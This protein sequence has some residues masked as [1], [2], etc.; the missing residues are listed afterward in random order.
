MGV[1]ALSFSAIFVREAATDATTITFFRALYAL[2][3][4]VLAW[5]SIRRRDHR[6]LRSRGLAV[7]AGGF[8]G[9]ELILWHLSIERIGASL[10]TVLVHTQVLFVALLAWALH[11]ERPTA[12]SLVLIPF[13]FV[14]VALLSGLGADTAYGDDPVAG[15]LFGVAAGAVYSGFLLGLRAS[16]RS[17]LAPTAGP[18][19]DATIGTAIAA[20]VIGVVAVPEFSLEPAW[21]AHGWLI[22]LAVVVQAVGWLLVATALPRLA[23]LDTS[24]LI[25]GQPV[26]TLLW[27]FLIFAE[28]L[29]GLQ[30]V[31]V[32]IV[33][34]GLVALNLTESVQAPPA[35]ELPAR[36][37]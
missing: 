12:R 28:D 34:I 33:L 9:V 15:V 35:E 16:N 23:A 30:W 2:P 36:P 22:L 10:A 1:V 8:L 21:P 31:G 14:G 19:L 27:A 32:V 6:P 17:H 5:W 25:L 29:S 4:L 37:G 24:A 13:V 7:A 20:L 18:V 26:L 3:V 11:R